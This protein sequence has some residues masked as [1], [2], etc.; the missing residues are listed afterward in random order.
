[1]FQLEYASNDLST[2]SCIPHKEDSCLSETVKIGNSLP[3]LMFDKSHSSWNTHLFAFSS[4]T[5][6]LLLT[7]LPNWIYQGQKP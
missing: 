5:I 2:L 7:E 3:S 1:M 6:L 4:P